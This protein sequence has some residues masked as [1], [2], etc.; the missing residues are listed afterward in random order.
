[1]VTYFAV[2]HGDLD[3]IYLRLDRFTLLRWVAVVA[4]PLGVYMGINFHH[5]IVDALIW[6]RRRQSPQPQRRSERSP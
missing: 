5:Y 1:M 2:L 6:K 4:S 3:V